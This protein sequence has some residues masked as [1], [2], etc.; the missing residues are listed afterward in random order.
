MSRLFPCA[1]LMTLAG[2]LSAQAARGRT[3]DEQVSSVLADV[4]RPG[5]A[6]RG[7]MQLARLGA[8]IVEPLF[9]HL[10]RG[11]SDLA[12]RAAMLGAL[13]QVAPDRVVAFL[14]ELARGSPT[15]SERQAGLDLLARFGSGAELPLTLALG[16]PAEA[17][18]PPSPAL[19]GALEDALAGILARSP[20]SERTLAEA[21]G[22]AT[23]AAR[24]SIAAV[25]ARRGTASTG[26][27]ADLLGRADE[28]ADTVVLLELGRVAHK[29]LPPFDAHVSER[30]RAFLSHPSEGLVVLAAGVCAALADDTAVPDLIVVLG[31]ARKNVRGAAHTALVRLTDERLAADEEAWLAWLDQGLAWWNER[32]DSCRAALA[33]G[34]PVEAAAAL[35]EASRQRLFVRELVPIL[36]LAVRRPELDLVRSATRALA[37]LPERVARTALTALV[38]TPDVGVAQ[39]AREA[40]SRIADRRPSPR[41]RPPLPHTRPMP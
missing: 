10:G 9:A 39:S 26:A 18:A 27:L 1:L 5:D 14:A 20:G 6:A 35:S 17:D 28:A 40:L 8:S 11:E 30:V 3:L 12:R 21:Y 19:R 22:S 2:Q 34:S 36:E 32:A 16:G 15:E 31:D 38:P 29:R 37:A 25:L 41:L 4:Q 7:A 23:P 13:A 33:S 24:S